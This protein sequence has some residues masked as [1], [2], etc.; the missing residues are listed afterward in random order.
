MWDWGYE[1][2]VEFHK[3][4]DEWWQKMK[5]EC[6]TVNMT[7]QQKKE[8]Y[9]NKN[10]PKAPPT[11]PPTYHD[12]AW[13]ILYILVMV[14]GCIFEDRWLIWIAATVIYVNYLRK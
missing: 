8:Y 3:R 4:Q 9:E 11:P 7:E 12:P 10:K 14:G 2:W 13:L 5:D 6:N 1:E